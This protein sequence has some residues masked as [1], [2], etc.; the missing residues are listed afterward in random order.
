MKNITEDIENLEKVLGNKKSRELSAK[1]ILAHIKS[2]D[3]LLGLYKQAYDKSNAEVMK[4][5]MMKQDEVTTLNNIIS[6]LDD[7]LTVTNISELI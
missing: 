5:F 7:T 2:Q 3:I 4:M 6:H 1:R